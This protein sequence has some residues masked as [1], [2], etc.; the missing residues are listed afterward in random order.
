V[1]LWCLAER[2]AGVLAAVA[3]RADGWARVM[4]VDFESAGASAL[5]L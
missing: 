4:R 2:S 3:A 1:L 5:T